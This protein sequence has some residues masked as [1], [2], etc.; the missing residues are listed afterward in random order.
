[1]LLINKECASIFHGE[2]A[3]ENKETKI[4]VSNSYLA[5]KA[6]KGTFFTRAL[7]SLYE[8]SL[9]ITLTVPLNLVNWFKGTLQ[10][11]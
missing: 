8:G 10:S 1:M 9:E 4:F 5:D 7:P 11:L 2:T 3:N 6:L